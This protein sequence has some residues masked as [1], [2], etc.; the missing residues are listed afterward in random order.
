MNDM[1]CTPAEDTHTVLLLIVYT[2]YRVCVGVAA[3]KKM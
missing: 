1:A 3:K 2:I